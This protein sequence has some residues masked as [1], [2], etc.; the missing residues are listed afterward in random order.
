M[1]APVRV[2]ATHARASIL[3]TTGNVDAD[4]GVVDFGGSK[5]RVTLTASM[6]MNLKMTATHFD[7]VMNAWSGG[8][9]RMLVPKGFG[10]AFQVMVERPRGAYLPGRFVFADEAAGVHFRLC[11]G[12]EE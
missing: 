9:L 10:T 4:G 7:G 3:N 11:G 1:S 8:P 5:G 2:T 6:E 12:W